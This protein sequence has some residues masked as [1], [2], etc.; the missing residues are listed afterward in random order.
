MGCRTPLAFA[1]HGHAPKPDVFVDVDAVF[2]VLRAGG[3]QVAFR[4][5]RHN[6]LPAENYLAENSESC[7][8]GFGPLKFLTPVWFVVSGAP[9]AMR[10]LALKRF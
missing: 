3:E 4:I 9:S 10:A 5:V 1:D 8:E 2:G 6:R 7:C